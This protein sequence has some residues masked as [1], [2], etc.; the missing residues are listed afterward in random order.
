MIDLAGKK[1]NRLTVIERAKNS[2]QGQA[3]W[4]CLCDCGKET[5]VLGGQLRSGKTKSCGCFNKENQKAY[6]DLTGKRFG[7]LTVVNRE[8][9]YI[10]QSG[11]SR[12]L[13]WNCLCDCGEKC[14]VNADALKRGFTRSCG[15]LHEENLIELWKRGK[16]KENRFEV[17][18]NIVY[19]EVEKTKEKI[20]CDLEDWEYLKEYC[21]YLDNNGYPM[22]ISKRKKI[23]MHRMILKENISEVVD[24]INR[25]KLDNRKENLRY[26]TNVVNAQN[27]SLQSNNKSGHVGVYKVKN[28]WVAW[29]GAYYKRI[30]LG[31][32]K[33][34][35]EAI[36]AREEAEKIYHKEKFKT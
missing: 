16:K 28:H 14:V 27:R 30:Y 19:I 9:N 11:S 15:C 1:F 26:T 21:W 22:T 6:K 5:I 34:K 32:F 7:R 4:K 23:F 31:S 33:T 24:H 35:E 25:N 10:S 3:R 17:V 29:I 18:G 2:K 12:S 13:R 8:E 36:K 20:M